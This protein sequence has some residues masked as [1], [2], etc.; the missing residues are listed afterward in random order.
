M[1]WSTMIYFGKPFVINSS[2][3]GLKYLCSF[4]VRLEFSADK[5]KMIYYECY[6]KTSNNGCVS[7]CS[8]VSEV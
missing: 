4:S 2:W 8:E 3:G 5:I 1:S 7:F 6:L